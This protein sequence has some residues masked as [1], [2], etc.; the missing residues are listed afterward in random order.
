MSEQTPEQQMVSALQENETPVAEVSTGGHPAWQ[1]IL[2]AVPESLHESIRPTLE[3]W[4]KGV[5]TRLE[6]VQSQYAPYKSFVDNSV[7]PEDLEAGMQLINAL[8]ADPAKFVENLRDY[9][10][11]SGESSGQGLSQPEGQEVDLSEYGE[12]LSNHPQF[13]QLKQ[14]QDS[15]AQQLEAQQQTQNA[16]DAEIWLNSRQAQI[17]DQ[18]KEQIGIEADQGAWDYMMNRA[19]VEAQRTNNFDK[20]LDNAR[21]AY[22]AF[23]NQYKAPVAAVIPNA[24]VVMPP[25][26]AVPVS[27][28]NST[29]LNEAQRKQL[30]VQMLGQA[31]REQ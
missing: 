25:N 21:D 27:N 8:N 1:E 23:V 22:V 12:D 20:A 24:P 7:S 13:K 29:T 11:L 10:K 19:Q 6:T 26:G 9:Y 17:S 14:M 18:L 15:I 2:S 4:D 16:K 3:N 5:N 28:F 30:M 31:F